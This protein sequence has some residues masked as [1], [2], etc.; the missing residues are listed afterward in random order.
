M[1]VDEPGRRKRA[2]EA[3]VKVN[4]AGCGIDVLDRIL[5]PSAHYGQSIDGIPRIRQSAGTALE[6][7]ARAA[8][9]SRLP[10]PWLLLRLMLPL[11]VKIPSAWP[12]SL[13]GMR[14]SGPVP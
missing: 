8:L 7:V 6:I 2:A 1:V 14:V 10:F 13:P 9:I 4:I 12:L 3:A 11:A 5:N